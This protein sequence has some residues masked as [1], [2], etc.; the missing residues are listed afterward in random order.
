MCRWISPLAA[1]VLAVG[2]AMGI[3]P[4]A[5]GKDDFQASTW[6]GIGRPAT[7]AELRAW[8]IDVR[9]DFAGLPAGR[10]SALQGQ[11]IWEAKCASCHGVFGESNAVFNPITGG[12]TRAD[13]ERGDVQS[14]RDNSFPGR[15]T[16]MKL[17]QISALW[18]YIRRAMPWNAPKSLTTDEVYAVT[19]YLL[20]LADLVPADFVL[21]DAN[22][23]QVQ[24]RLPARDT[25]TTAHH[26]WSG[27]GLPG[28]T[29][30]PDVQGSRCMRDCPVGARVTSLMPD[31]ALGAHGDLAQQQRGIGPLRGLRTAAD[32]PPAAGTARAVPEWVGRHGCTACHAADRALVG[33]AFREIA[34]RYEGRADAAAYL[35]DKIVRGSQGVW[36]A[37]VMPPQPLAPEEAARIAQWLLSAAAPGPAQ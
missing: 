2:T 14:L 8:D 11:V 12:T 10:G 7:E 26:L 36:G 3:M 37:A 19:A 23:A 30:K 33:P 28:A 27:D 24:A 29:R 18:D 17:S 5:E 13:A 31:Y 15:S 20:H 21:S 35:S 4:V 34:R 9:P 6:S 1:C 32:A 25:P 22:I 16:F